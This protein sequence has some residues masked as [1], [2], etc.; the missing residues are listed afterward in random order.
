M[1]KTRR[2]QEVCQRHD[3][4]LPAAVQFPLGHPL[5]SA[6]IPGAM[7]PAHIQTNIGWFQHQIS[8]ALWAEL[9]AAGLQGRRANASMKQV[10]LCDHSPAAGSP[11]TVLPASWEYRLPE[12]NSS[13]MPA[14]PNYKSFRQ[15]NKTPIPLL[16]HSRSSVTTPMAAR[17]FNSDSLQD[18][19]VRELASE[20]T[21]PVKEVLESFEFFAG[22]RKHVRTRC[23]ADLCCGHGLTGILF[24]LFER[25]V[26]RAVLI[27][28][29]QPPS[30]AK[31]LAAAIR[32]GPWVADKVEYQTARMQD[33][34]QYI[35][36]KTSVIAAHACGTL[37]D[38]C[39]D[40][41]IEAAGA[42]AL[43]PC[44]YPDRDCQPQPHYSCRWQPFS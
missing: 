29:E 36:P 12:L 16:A 1:E 20:K 33:V 10:V 3:V 7:E 24:A 15:F 37:T 34:S 17:V 38:H 18:R 39:I 13:A 4:P 22:A 30:H 14:K 35:E 28:R 44:Y 31:A 40:C 21:L 26:E 11:W 2:I 32:V 41:A 5:V 42:V 9:K 27:D 8:T 23:V 25:T 43:M 19:Y 6:I